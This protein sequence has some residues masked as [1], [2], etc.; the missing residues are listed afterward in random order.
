MRPS[1]W[2]GF[3][4]VAVSSLALSAQGH[5][6]ALSIG[7]DEYQ[8]ANHLANAGHDATAIGRELVKQGYET[9][10]RLNL[11]RRKMVDTIEIF[12][13]QIQ[14]GDTVLFY[15]A[16]HGLQVNGENLLV[17][18]DF[19]AHR[20]GDALLT[21]YSLSKVLE[22]FI[23]RGA[24]TRII[25]LDSCR[26]NPFL[27][28]RSLKGGWAGMGTSAGTLIAFGT[29]PG[30]T[31]ADDPGRD[32][33]LF[34][35]KLLNRF[36]S[37]TGIE[38][39]LQFVRQDVI[40]ASG[41]GQIP[42]V[43]S[44]LTGEFHLLPTADRNSLPQPILNFGFPGEPST[45]ARSLSATEQEANS[46]L[47]R[48]SGAD[49][50]EARLTPPSQKVLTTLTP[51]QEQVLLEE[52]IRLAGTGDFDDSVRSLHA[53]LEADPTSSLALRIL[54][55]VFHL[56]GRSAVAR[57]TLSR[58][59]DSNPQDANALYYRCM[60]NAPIDP[61]MAIQD[62]E[63]AISLDPTNANAHVIIATALLDRGQSTDAEREVKQA[64]ELDPNNPLAASVHGKVL[65]RLGRLASAESEFRRAMDDQPSEQKQPF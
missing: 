14:P 34:T 52:A 35:E 13:S 65:M 42:W 29:S 38:Q 58:A 37:P 5:R 57:E 61:S 40:A 19:E 28:Q 56:M 3:L 47:P 51:K 16:G 27:G 49:I 20:P 2:I 48:T 55:L 59:I 12:S 45:A 41:G 18:T 25:I 31:A 21:G 62:C 17:P 30:A 11:D 63:A 7:N 6:R 26:D 22:H 60:V 9:T 64:I 23:D 44:S 54:G 43:A 50:V 53:I 1:A 24:T 33:G 4:C 46:Y 8:Y 39:T 15:Y 32:H 10:V 36:E